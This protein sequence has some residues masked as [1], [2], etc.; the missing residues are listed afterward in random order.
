VS[1]AAVANN[2]TSKNG[3]AMATA[4]EHL[5]GCMQCKRMAAFLSLLHDRKNIDR[6]PLDPT[7]L[8]GKSRC[9]KRK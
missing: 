9:F 1:S 5:V 3:G 6:R 8:I 2:I 7:A 4:N